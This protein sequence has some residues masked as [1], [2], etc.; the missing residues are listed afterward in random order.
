MDY[1]NALG[2]GETKV[3]YARVMIVGPGGVG[4]SSL[5]NGLMNLPLPC[6]AYSTQVADTFSL[7]PTESYWACSQEKKY[8]TKITDADEIKAMAQLIQT[9]LDHKDSNSATGS[10]VSRSQP[11]KTAPKFD[12]T[13]IEGILKEILSV[14]STDDRFLEEE[15]Y[16]HVWDCGG[17]PIFLKILPAFLTARTLFLLMFD[18]RRDLHDQCRSLTYL[19]GRATEHLEDISTL[20]LMVQWISTIHTTLLN[21]RLFFN[22]ERDEEEEVPKYPR[23]LPVGSHGDNI[24]VKE[25]KHEILEKLSSEITNKVFSDIVLDGAIIDNTTAGKGEVEED[26]TFKLIRETVSRFATKDLAIRTPITWLLFRKVFQRYARSEKKPVV[27]LEEVKKLCRACLIPE[28]TLTSILAFYHDLAVFFHYSD[29]PSLESCVIADPQW[30]IKQIARL[31]A[32]EGREEYRNDHLWKLLREDGILVESLYQVVLRAQKELQPQQIVDLLEHFLIIARIST[33]KH[34]GPGRK[35]FVPSML[36]HLPK[37]DDPHSTSTAIKSA[38]PLHLVFST[39]YLPPGFFTQLAAVLS[40]HPKCYLPVSE[41][42]YRNQI[43]FLFGSPGQ[44]LDRLFITEEKLSVRIDVQRIDSREYK[45]PTFISSC[46]DILEILQIS[47]SDIKKWL[48]GI[49]INFA[50]KCEGCQQKD[51][52]VV[53][54]SSP[55]TSN[56]A[57]ICQKG[58]P[59]KLTVHQKFWFNIRQVSHALLSLHNVFML[60]FHFMQDHSANTIIS[61]SEL[62]A[63]AIEVQKCEKVKELAEALEMSEHLEY[64]NNDA[65]ELLEQWQKEMNMMNVPA[66][67]YLLHHLSCIGIKDMQIK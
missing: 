2:Q 7:R 32:L 34:K 37:V 14:I 59:T 13:L 55:T 28:N 12:Y 21:K 8:W 15:V 3:A 57:L 38:I 16:L 24:S 49:D 65:K 62:E 45:C 11:S 27:S 47:S 67:P 20:D 63:I 29:I 6:E 19:K 9:I 44:Q 30:L 26:E 36:P 39:N 35:Y 61:S 43:Q 23:I 48:P 4:K 46:H 60:Y 51:H 25:R 31:L 18:A 64:I 1:L 53:L 50:L 5:L 17:Q 42:I 40:K 58:N 56:P 52:F 33:E 54:P 22:K 10:D 41:K 66:R